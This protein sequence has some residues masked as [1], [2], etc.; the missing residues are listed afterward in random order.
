MGPTP[1]N[2][3]PSTG[4]QAHVRS[5]LLPQV[6][7]RQDG[8]HHVILLLL[9][10]VLILIHSF[11]FTEELLF[12]SFLFCSIWLILNHPISELLI[13]SSIWLIS[14]HP[15]SEHLVFLLFDWF[16]IPHF[17]AFGSFF[18]LIYFQ[19]PHFRAFCFSSIWLVSNHLM[20]ER[21]KANPNKG[22]CFLWSFTRIDLSN[23]RI[24]CQKACC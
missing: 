15:I 4:P 23:Y 19:S 22:S 1:Q 9:V 2:L 10:V 6:L 14:N 8:P 18:Y 17:R 7:H 3:E 13:F 5:P 20:L 16:P 12:V 24:V 11:M 21:N